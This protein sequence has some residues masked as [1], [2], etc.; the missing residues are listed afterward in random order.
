MKKPFQ[1]RNL[2]PVS[3]MFQR[4]QPTHLSSTIHGDSSGS[5]I[6]K[7][8]RKSV[9]LLLHNLSIKQNMWLYVKEVIREY[10]AFGI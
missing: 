9:C 3:G 8:G 7:E 4:N 1:K 5:M 6:F 10:V 2:A